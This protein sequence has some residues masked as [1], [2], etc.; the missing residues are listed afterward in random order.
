MDRVE[1]GGGGG[2]S[3]KPAMARRDISISG[4][5]ELLGATSAA[6]GGSTSNQDSSIR[7]LVGGPGRKRAAPG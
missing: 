2:P 7:R 1:A 5:H 4:I 6:C 3:S